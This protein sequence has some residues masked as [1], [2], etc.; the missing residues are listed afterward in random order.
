MVLGE[1]MQAAEAAKAR[2]KMQAVVST[3]IT[4][5][6]LLAKLNQFTTPSD[7]R[8]M[9]DNLYKVLDIDDNGGVN[10]EEFKAGLCNIKLDSP[11]ELSQED[12][13]IMTENGTRA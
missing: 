5:D 8:S 13:H 4:L 3:E 2:R 7:L 6:P 1:V 9:I 12:W 10:Y 11:V